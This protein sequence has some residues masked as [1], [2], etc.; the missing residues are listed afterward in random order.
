MKRALQWLVDA[1]EAD[2]SLR[3]SDRWR[4]RIDVLDR[5]EDALG[6]EGDAVLQQRARALCDELDVINH[7][8][9]QEIRQE[10][11]Q[12]HTTRALMK[13]VPSPLFDDGADRHVSGERYDE[14]DA[15]LDGVLQLQEPVSDIAALDPEMVFYQPTPARHIFDML[16]RVQLEESDVLVDLGSGMGHVPL[17]AA[18]CTRARGVGVELESAYVTRAQQCAS[19]LNLAHV[20]FV[21]QDVR[22]ADLSEGTVFYLYT[23][24]TGAIWRSV[25]DRLAQEAA[26]RALRI[27]TLGPCTTLMAGEPWLK[28]TGSLH[29]DRIAVFR[30][31]QE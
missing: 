24:F 11:Q 23:P 19:A 4:Q 9:Y 20:R 26:K 7:R 6:E 29:A 2:A 27:C 14:L 10:I 12:T 15:L 13:W 5:L 3:E 21:A 31:A 18:I 28:A 1:C 17:L 16:G 25:M 30:S 22:S 8:I